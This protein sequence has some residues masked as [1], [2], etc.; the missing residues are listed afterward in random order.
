MTK[1]T[2]NEQI[3]QILAQENAQLEQNTWQGKLK[4]V[5]QAQNRKNALKAELCAMLRGLS[6]KG[7]FT[8]FLIVAFVFML[9]FSVL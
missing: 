7:I 4:R 6:K 9:T 5:W 8:L 2:L 1:P 3:E